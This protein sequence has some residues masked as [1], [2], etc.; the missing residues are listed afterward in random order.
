MNEADAG[1]TDS[2]PPVNGTSNSV[3][4]VTSPLDSSGWDGKA[5]VE[6]KA[7]LANL[8]ALSDPEYSDEDAPP[9]DQIEADEGKRFPVMTSHGFA[10]LCVMKTCSKI[11]NMTPTYITLGRL[12]STSSF[13]N[14]LAFFQEIDLVHSRIKNIPALGLER[15]TDLK[16]L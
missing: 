13:T 12:Q 4:K 1:P 9:V 11:M 5:R 2:S 14:S 7:V 16:V 6:R 15:F 10:D 3:P 8:E